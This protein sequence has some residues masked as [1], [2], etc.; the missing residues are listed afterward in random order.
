M[1]RKGVS[2]YETVA[3]ISL[4]AVAWL[5]DM[6][7]SRY[8]NSYGVIGMIVF[9]L[10]LIFIIEKL[11]WL[12]RELFLGQMPFPL[13]RCGKASIDTIPEESVDG[14]IQRKCSCGRKFNTSGRRIIT[15]I[16]NGQEQ[17]YA[18]WQPFKGWILHNN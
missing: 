18:T 5:G 12:E 16:E 9:P 3:L 14:H 15:T 1:N 10:A 17:K 13:C 7:G 4:I 6:F 11:A 8:G 2:I